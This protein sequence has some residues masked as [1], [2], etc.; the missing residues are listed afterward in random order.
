MVSVHGL[1]LEQALL[2]H[3]EDVLELGLRVKLF[4][5]LLEKNI[6][7]LR[8]DVALGT[9]PDAILLA[10]IVLEVLR[11]HIFDDLVDEHFGFEPLLLDFL[12][13]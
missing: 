12:K 9:Q 11:A 8:V 6:V 5:E 4:L 13:F 2:E 7:A 10:E 3:L 1:G